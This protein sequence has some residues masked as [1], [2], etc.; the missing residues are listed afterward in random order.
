[1]ANQNLVGVHS[2][3]IFMIVVM[4]LL[5][6]IMNYLPLHH[7]KQ[8]YISKCVTALTASSQVKHPENSYSITVRYFKI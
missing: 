3:Q 4:E 5:H 1:M 2:V 6:I 7:V 8:H